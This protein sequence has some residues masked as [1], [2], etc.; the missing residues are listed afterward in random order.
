MIYAFRIKN[1]SA[2]LPPLQPGSPLVTFDQQRDE[3]ITTRESWI[4]Q[5]EVSLLKTRNITLQITTYSVP[6]RRLWQGPQ[7]S[8]FQYSEDATEVMPPSSDRSNVVP[9]KCIPIV[10]GDKSIDRDDL[11]G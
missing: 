9:V 6:S 10:M 4:P 2:I 7:F 11:S 3:P 1:S 5:L 8:F